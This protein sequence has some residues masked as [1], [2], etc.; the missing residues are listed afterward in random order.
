MQGKEMTVIEGVERYKKACKKHGKIIKAKELSEYKNTPSYGW[1][2]RQIGGMK[3]LREMA[4]LDLE[5]YK[6]KE[7]I[8]ISKKG[9]CNDC[10]H[11]N[12]TCGKEVEDCIEEA[13]EDGYIEFLKR[14]PLANRR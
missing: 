14:V 3:K 9:F 1:I 10:L 4:G 6:E 2:N 7:K 13:K 5:K 11:W 12:R 8:K